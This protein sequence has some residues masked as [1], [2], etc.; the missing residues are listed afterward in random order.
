[1]A[2]QRSCLTASADDPEP[3]P[4]AATAVVLPEGM[5]AAAVRQRYADVNALWDKGVGT[6]RI[7]DQ[8][9][10]DPKTVRRYAHAATVEEMLTTPRLG[11]RAL[12][13]YVSY[14][15]QRWNEGCTDS[16]RLYRELQQL[17]YSGSSRSVRR[18]LEPL[19]ALDSPLTRIPE[20][21]TARQVTTW[22]TRHPDSLTSDESLKL[23]RVLDHC[24]ELTDTAR[25]VRDFAKTMTRLDGERFPAWIAAA[26]DASV[27]PLRR[28]AR[29]IRKDLPAVVQ[30][31][32]TPCN[33]GIV[34]GRV[35]DIKATKRQMAGR[36]GFQLLRKRILLVAASRRPPNVTETSVS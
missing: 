12:S 16:G 31:L 27:P 34:E 14:L 36:A 11:R 6:G 8:L 9:G 24:P 7:C 30:G 1:M 32:S 29:N 18:W 23:K 5:R 28:F 19:R 3:A 35:T 10:L 15:N 22:L 26:D 33:S 2:T 25:H 20:T 21:P 4:N 13:R 17:G